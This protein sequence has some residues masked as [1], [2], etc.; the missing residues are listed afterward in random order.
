MH[1]PDTCLTI[2]CELRELVDKTSDSL[3]NKEM[4]LSRLMKCNVE[5]EGNIRSLMD[6]NRQLQEEIRSLKNKYE[7]QRQ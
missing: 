7:T 5:N 6:E 3:V 4:E 1:N 2:I